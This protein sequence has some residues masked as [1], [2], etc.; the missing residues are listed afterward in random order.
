MNRHGFN[1]H[2]R[3]IY[4]LN[5]PGRR[6]CP[7]IRCLYHHF[8]KMIYSL[9]RKVCN[10]IFAYFTQSSGISPGTRSNSFVFFVTSTARRRWRVRQSLCRS[11]RSASRRGVTRR[12]VRSGIHCSAIPGQNGINAGAECINQRNMTRRGLRTGSA[13]RISA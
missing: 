9:S 6:S 11:V 5:P 7:G 13:K 10:C 3:V 2:V 1:R 4:G 12:D 8:F